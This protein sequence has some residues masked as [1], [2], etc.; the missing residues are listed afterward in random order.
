MNHISWQG[1]MVR[2]VRLIR[3]Q[4]FYIMMHHSVYIYLHHKCKVQSCEEAA[5]RN[6]LLTLLQPPQEDWVSEREKKGQ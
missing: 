4:A 3:K 2:V 1:C 6:K 5:A